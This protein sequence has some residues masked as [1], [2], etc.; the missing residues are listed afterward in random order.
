MKVIFV[1]GS[2]H[3]DGTTM[4]L[5]KEMQDIFAAEHIDTEVIQ[6]GNKAME[7]CIQ[8][9]YC[10]KH[11]RCVFNDDE[12]NR[13]VEKAKDA[14]GFVFAT[15]VYYAHPSGRILSFLDRVFFSAPKGKNSLE[16][17]RCLWRVQLIGIL[18]MAM[19]P[20]RP[21]RMKKECRLCEILPEI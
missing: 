6:L 14:D 10:F 8:C 17:R 20:V 15:P 9:G 2:S 11:N 5:V 13:F 16:F 18:V 12:V 7:D 3:R 1:N 4:Q 19:R 21:R